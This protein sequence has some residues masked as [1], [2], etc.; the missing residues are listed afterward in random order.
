LKSEYGKY[1]FIWIALATFFL[2]LLNSPGTVCLEE[3]VIVGEIDKAGIERLFGAK[4]SPRIIIMMA[5]WCGPCREEL[6]TLTKLCSKYR[7]DGLKMVGVSFEYE[8]PSAIQ[9]IL[10]RFRVNFPV[11]CADAQVLRDYRISSIP[12]F[13]FIKDGQIVEKLIGRRTEEF[14]EGKIR[15]LL[16]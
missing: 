3:R 14:L 6:P 4:D 1:P 16:K 11:Y 12:M 8:H 10:D 2:T 7:S 9:A 5:S 13:F 15:E